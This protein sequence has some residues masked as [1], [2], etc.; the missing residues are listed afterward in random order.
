MLLNFKIHYVK[1]L[2]YIVVLVFSLQTFSHSNSFFC[3]IS[4]SSGYNYDYDLRDYKE[5][6]FIVKDYIIK[7]VDEEMCAYK[8]E[9]NKIGTYDEAF[10]REYICMN[11]YEFGETEV[12]NFIVCSISDNETTFRC[13]DPTFGIGFAFNIDG[14][15]YLGHE[16]PM[17]VEG[18]SEKEAKLPE[19]DWDDLSKP[20]RP[21][22]TSVFL[23]KGKCSKIE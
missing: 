13:K 1:C 9:F 7:I 6:N 5:T 19:I 16:N 4:S 3:K 20:F 22:R 12:P 11:K 17:Q 21:I 23:E 2:V 15:I 14:G 18:L 8:E 10:Q